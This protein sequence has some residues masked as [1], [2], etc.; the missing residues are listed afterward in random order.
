MRARSRDEAHRFFSGWA[1]PD[2][3]W[4]KGWNA[5]HPGSTLEADVRDQWAKG[6]VGNKGDWK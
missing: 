6:N 4:Q 3:K 1:K 5:Q 2:G